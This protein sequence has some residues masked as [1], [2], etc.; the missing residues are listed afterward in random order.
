MITS[1]LVSLLQDLIMVLSVFGMPTISS[2]TAQLIPLLI[3]TKRV[4]S[5]SKRSM[6]LLFIP[7]PSTH[8]DST[9]LLVVVLKLQFIILKR[10]LLNQMSS[11]QEVMSIKEALLL[12]CLGI[13]KF[14]TFL[15]LL[16]KTELP[17]FGILN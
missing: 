10:T 9:S 15:V 14:L 6:T 1:Q 13:E 17:L 12:Q 16:P 2:K 4:L 8:L 3:I 7:L 5:V 11:A